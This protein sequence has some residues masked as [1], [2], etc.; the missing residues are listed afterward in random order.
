[1]STPN[2][3][4]PPKH[5]PASCPLHDTITSAIMTHPHQS[6]NSALSRLEAARP[7]RTSRQKTKRQTAGVPHAHCHPP[8]RPSPP[9]CP[10][11]PGCFTH[12]SS[13]TRRAFTYTLTTFSTQQE[14]PCCCHSRLRR[15][16]R[17]PTA[18][19]APHPG[20]LLA[21][22]IASSHAHTREPVLDTSRLFS[23]QKRAGLDKSPPLFL[24]STS[25]CCLRHRCHNA[26]SIGC[27]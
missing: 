8:H 17:P 14:R 10:V 16:R 26:D 20:P 4:P 9:L 25:V 22:S 27:L 1:M 11:C 13:L 24:C 2:H 18:A 15:L 3:L 21:Q 12:P 6:E 5:L 19:H 23:R 7:C